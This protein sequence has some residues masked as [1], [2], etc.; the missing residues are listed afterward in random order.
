MFGKKYCK[1]YLRVQNSMT[2]FLPTN[3]HLSCYNPPE[4]HPLDLMNNFKE[5]DN[6]RENGFVPNLEKPRKKILLNNLKI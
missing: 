5:T 3:I 6:K 4:T 2:L 1:G